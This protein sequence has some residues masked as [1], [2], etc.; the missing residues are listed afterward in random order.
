MHRRGYGAPVKDPARRLRGRLVRAAGRGAR[1]CPVCEREAPDGFLPLRQRRQ[2]IC[3]H[4][5]SR[6]RHRLL[7][8]FLTRETDLLERPARLLHVAP[9]QGIGG[10]LAAAGNIDYVSG[11]LEPGRALEVLDV[12]AIDHPDASFDVVLCNHV[13]EHV[14][15]DRAALRELRRVTRPDG[16]ALIQVPM[17]RERTDEDPSVTDPQERLR[18]FMQADHVRVYGR[19]FLD[20]LREAGWAPETHV[21]RDRFSQREKRR[22]GLEHRFAPNAAGHPRDD[23][24]WEVVISRPA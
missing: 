9:D 1:W 13:L 22:M 2:A 7:W 17:L 15:D 12:T 18:R 10:R 3:P 19:D 24:W 8:L 16:W 5:G 23:V 21:L 14:P 20:R 6:E 11:D 4:C